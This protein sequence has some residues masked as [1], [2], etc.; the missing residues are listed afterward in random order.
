M[1]QNVVSTLVGNLFLSRKRVFILVRITETQGPTGR[2]IKSNYAIS[3]HFDCLQHV[4]AYS[5]ASIQLR[6]LS[7]IMSNLCLIA[8]VELRRKLGEAVV[9]YL[10]VLPLQFPGRIDDN[11]QRH[12]ASN[13][14][15]RDA[16][17]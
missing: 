2:F 15:L 14:G 7:Y 6:N 10:N 13:F 8:N 9:M 12:V 4:F 5:K 16:H 1:L 3:I 17:E 11:R